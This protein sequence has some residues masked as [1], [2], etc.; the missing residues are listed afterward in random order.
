MTT[1]AGTASTDP[2]VMTQR[3]PWRSRIRPTGMPTAAATSWLTE[4][5]ATIT[6]VDHPVSREMATDRTGNA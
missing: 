2:V 6:E 3:G 5:A 1:S 4:N